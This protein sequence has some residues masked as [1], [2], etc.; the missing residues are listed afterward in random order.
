MIM[1]IK[2]AFFTLAMML[3]FG[4]FASAQLAEPVKWSFKAQSLVDN[5][6]EVTLTADIAEGW[7][8]YSQYLSSDDGPIRTTIQF[9]KHPALELK[10]KTE[11]KGHKKEGY[12][13][14]F[15]MNVIKFTGKTQFTQKIVVKAADLH[16]VRG[17]LQYMTCNGQMCMPPKDIRFKVN[18]K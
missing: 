1:R 2:T 11:E 12:D 3:G 18:L 6:Y 4:T 13:Q 8:L 16:L 9:E 14:M 15:G 7:F 17:T 5:E 10:G